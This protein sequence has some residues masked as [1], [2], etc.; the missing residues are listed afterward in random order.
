MFKHHG[1][2]I[3]TITAFFFLV[4]P[5]FSQ[6]AGWPFSG[7]D[8]NNSRWASDE[9]ILTP[10]NVG[11]L[12]VKWQFT[13][14]NDVSATP[15]V[16]PT[17]S[18]VYFPDWSG[19]LY[20]LETATGTPIWTRKIS[21]YGLCAQAMSRTSPALYGPLVIIGASASLA[22]PS[23]CGS[24]LLAVNASDGSLVWST[25][26][27]PSVNSLST[28]SPI[29]YNGVAYIGVSSTEEK[30]SSPTFRG[31]LVAVSMTNG[32][33][34]WQTYF[35]PK[36]YSGA[37]IW[38]STP[39]IDT[40]HKQIYVTTGNNYLVPPSVQAC[41]Q[42]ASQNPRQIM[43]C[44]AFDNYE[45]SIVAL[46][47]NSGNVIWGHRCSLDDAWIT[48]C[49][50]RLPACPDPTGS[51]LDFGSGANLFTT[52]IYGN[53]VSL[54]GAGQKNGVYWAL[55]PSTGS[56]AWTTS[57][58]PGGVLGGVQ[59][60]TASDN[61]RIYA[62]ISNTYQET[63]TLQPSGASWNGASWAAMN[64][65][66]GKILWQVKDPGMS[67]AHPDQHALALGPVTVANGVVY[68]ASM[69]GHI[70]ALDAG[71]GATLWSFKAPGSVNSGPAIVH[72]TLYWGTG[73][74]NFPTHDP[75][76]TKSNTFYAFALPSGQLQAQTKP[77]R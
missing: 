17:G 50:H 28:A 26:L 27:D 56:A 5:A 73:Y 74:H 70:Y 8:L 24:Y 48:A 61:Q 34:L 55:S 21:E 10:Q 64:P 18:Y 23:P 32:Q 14:Q 31:S 22:N 38:S 13:T 16:D 68:V 62:A 19:N 41:E 40:A 12:T 77:A 33:I 58:G 29:Y 25:S 9:T 46:D 51:D 35:V 11:T 47:L 42:A 54:V 76:G 45:D 43:L 63:Y 1:V 7:K 2:L 65:A 71:T 72:G 53:T 37:P 59:W 49:S 75:L 39:V 44:Q 20:K 15:S 66:T 4:L 52:T 67:T 60:G 57:L 30:L 36:G 69:S 3:T 6:I